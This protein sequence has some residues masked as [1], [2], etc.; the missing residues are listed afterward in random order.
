MALPNPNPNQQSQQF[1]ASYQPFSAREAIGTRFSAALLQAQ[2]AVLSKTLLRFIPGAGVLSER[3]DLKKREM[4]EQK[5]RDPNTG[6][7]LTK[8]EIAEKEARKYDRGAL[9]EIRDLYVNEY[10]DTGVPVIFKQDNDSWFL[11][12]RLEVHLMDIKNA[13]TAGGMGVFSVGGNYASNMAGSS[14]IG[15]NRDTGSLSLDDVPTNDQSELA[16]QEAMDEREREDDEDQL[17]AEERQ[18]GFFSKLFGGLRGREESSNNSLF[19]TLIT[20]I[21]GLGTL[22]S[23]LFSK[24]IGSM[25]SNLLMKVLGGGGG[26]FDLGMGRGGR[27]RGRIGR[28]V[29]GTGR[30]LGGAARAVGSAIAST[31]AGQTIAQ[32]GGEIAKGARATGGAIARAGSAIAGYG[33]KAL[34]SVKAVGSSVTQ[35]G[36][37]WLSRAFGAVKNTAGRALGAVSNLNPVKAITGFVSKNAGKL[38]KGLTSIPALGAAIQGVIGALNIRSI[39]ND[40]TLSVDERKEAIGKA[41]GAMLGGAIGTIGGGALGSLIPVPGI[42]TILGSLGGGWVG[43]KVGEALAEAIGPKGIYDFVE[44]IPGVGSLVSISDE[45]ETPAEA[46]KTTTDASGKEIPATTA[47]PTGAVEGAMPTGTPTAVPPSTVPLSTGQGMSTTP[48]DI[49]SSAAENAALKTAPPIIAPT[50][51]TVANVSNNNSATFVGPVSASRGTGIDM[52][53]GYNGSGFRL[54]LT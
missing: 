2:S 30:I 34:E 17:E 39:A 42:G 27:M 52:D 6:R 36:G 47:T 44:S 20:A 29:S 43:E 24:Y 23:G 37:G 45:K 53:S 26:G 28:V 13:L 11:L 31:G 48:M 41:I 40:V 35:S 5:G 46:A 25:L 10:G 51:N 3:A 7:K 8:D 16:T 50:S 14:E 38:L 22:V 1:G 54:S 9:G 12:E 49:P 32:A 21:S 33:G 4:Y 15:A 19:G 18:Q